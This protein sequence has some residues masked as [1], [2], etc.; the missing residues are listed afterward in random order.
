[1][2]VDWQGRMMDVELSTRSLLV[3]ETVCDKKRTACVGLRWGW[4]AI[5]CTDR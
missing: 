2:K 5:S 1:L 4:T 3:N